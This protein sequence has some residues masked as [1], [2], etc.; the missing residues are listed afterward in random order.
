MRKTILSLALILS[1]GAA[2][3]DPVEGIWKTQVDDGAYAHVTI[4]PCGGAL[5]GTISRTFNADGEYKSANLGK[6]LVWDMQSKGG[7]DYRDGKIWQPSTDKVFKSKMALSGNT[8]KVSGCVGP[9]C[10]KQTWSRVK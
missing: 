6:K 2:H 1:A 5:C 7:G 9:I 4:A 10:K 8:L 3:A